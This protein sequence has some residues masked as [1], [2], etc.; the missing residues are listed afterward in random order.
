MCVL[1]EIYISKKAPYGSPAKFYISLKFYTQNF[2][3]LPF[4]S[5]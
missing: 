2:G 3:I 5:L 4:L 1:S